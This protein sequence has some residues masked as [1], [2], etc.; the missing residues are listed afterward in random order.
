MIGDGGQS[1]F[2][3]ADPS[4]RFHTFY[5][6]TPDVNFSRRR[7]G[8]LELDRRSDLS[9]T[10]PQS[11]YM[12]IITDPVEISWNVC[13]HRPRVADEDLGH[14]ADEPRRVPPALQRVDRGLRG[15]VR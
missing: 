1:G 6:A 3:A 7:H 15:H 14:G 2:D 4:F 9:G 5:D 10:E 13:R 12:P 11:F 8:G